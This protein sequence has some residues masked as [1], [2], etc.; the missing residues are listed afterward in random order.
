L[1]KEKLIRESKY[2]IICFCLLMLSF[3]IVFYKESLIVIIRIIFSLYWMF[4]LPGLSLMYIFNDKLNFFER[5]VVGI[6]VSSAILGILSYYLALFGF[7]V[8]NHVYFIP[9]LIVL[10][11]IIVYFYKKK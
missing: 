3:K 11:S 10:I 9:P 1:S 6:A 4:I 7:H 2:L 8:N 5:L